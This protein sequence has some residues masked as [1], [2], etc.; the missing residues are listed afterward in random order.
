MKHRTGRIA[1]LLVA[2]AVLVT[3]VAVPA[4]AGTPTRKLAMG[5]SLMPYDDM[6]HLDQFIADTGRKPALYTLWSAW[7]NASKAF[8]TSLLQQLDA[9]PGA[10]GR[11][12]PVIMWEPVDPNNLEGT[13]YLYSKIIAGN[14]DAYLKQWA[15][16]AKAYGKKVLVRAFPEM[17]GYWWPW[18][19]QFR[20]NSPA[21]FIKAWQHVWNVVRGE[22]ATNVRFLWAPFR[23]CNGCDTM[24][25]VWPGGKY[26]DFAG[27][28]TFNWG[29]WMKWKEMKP[30]F[31]TSYTAL[32]A[33]TAKPIIV[34]ETGSISAKADGSDKAAW[35]ANGYPAVYTA[36]PQIRGILYFNIDVTG[37]DERDWRLTVPTNKPLLA[38]KNLLTKPK[39]QGV[40]S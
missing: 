6:N 16:D 22:G 37:K 38:Y 28:S 30:L 29:G 14:H 27:F 7:G 35:I 3:G 32:T 39:F 13:Q 11:I 4:S 36:Y 12:M 40:I 5:V 18:G 21:K 1:L 31:K 8:P 33:I 17:N 9:R 10:G 26:V 34:T 15:Q 25:S 24:R 23:E 20:T 19:T 2:L